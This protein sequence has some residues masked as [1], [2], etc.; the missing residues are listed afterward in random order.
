MGRD[1]DKKHGARRESP[2]AKAIER[3]IDYGVKAIQGGASS[4]QEEK[5]KLIEAEIIS[6]KQKKLLLKELEE[7]I[8]L[9]I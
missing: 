4:G 6:F 1:N 8:K 2:I 9:M 3:K 7:Q 5:I